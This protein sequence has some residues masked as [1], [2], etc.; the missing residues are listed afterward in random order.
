MYYYTIFKNQRTGKL[1]FKKYKSKEKQSRSIVAI[2]RLTNNS[3]Y[4]NYTSLSDV[5]YIIKINN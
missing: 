5:K 1:W 3:H 2:I 4:Y